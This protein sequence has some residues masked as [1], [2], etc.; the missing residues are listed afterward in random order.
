[1][2][3]ADEEPTIMLVMIVM[4][5]QQAVA[6]V[7]QWR[8]RIVQRFNVPKRTPCLF[9][10]CGLAEQPAGHSAFVSDLRR[11]VISGVIS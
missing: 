4:W 9:A 2:T 10:C 6:K 8:S 3:E 7:R 5:K 1:M 11:D